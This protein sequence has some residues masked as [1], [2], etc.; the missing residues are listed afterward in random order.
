[1]IFLCCILIWHGLIGYRC[2]W[3]LRDD[4]DA[5]FSWIREVFISTIDGFRSKSKGYSLD[6]DLGGNCSQMSLGWKLGYLD[7][8][9]HY[10]CLV[11]SIVC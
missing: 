6:M 4:G 11:Y 7:E 2:S 10:P 3:I 8:H 5:D 1:M 9:S